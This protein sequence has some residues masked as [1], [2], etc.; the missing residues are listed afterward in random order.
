MYTLGKHHWRTLSEGIEKEWLMANGLGGFANGTVVGDTSRIHGGYLIAALNPPVDRK[1]I[2]SKTQERICRG[3]EEID[4][5]C[6]QY[7]GFEKNGQRYL[8]RFTL[9][10]VPVFFY[11]VDDLTIRKTVAMEYGKN[12]VAVCYEIHNG[13]EPASFHVTPL[14]AG[15]PMDCVSEKSELRFAVQL[16]ENL[17]QLV[18]QDAPDVCISFYTSAGSYY[19]RAQIPTSLATPNYLIEENQLYAIDR[20]NGFCGLDNH[21]TP[22]D[23][24]VSLKPWEE[25]RFFVLCTTEQD[26]DFSAV[27]GFAIADAYRQRRKNL[28][29]RALQQDELVRKLAW[30]A[31]PFIVQRNSTGLKTVLAGFPWFADWG[32]D[33]MIAVTGLTL[34]TGRS[35]DC[36]EILESFS[37]YVQN[38][39]IP[40][41]FPNSSSEQPM[42]NTI[43][44]SLWYFYAV[45]RYLTYTKTPEANEFIR[46]AIYPK[47]KEILYA[48]QH[49]TDFS[50]QMQ[51]DGLIS[52][53][54]DRDQITWM[55]VRVGDWV[56]TPRHGKPVEIN[57]LW[58]NALKVMEQL[59][60][61]YGED[62]SAYAH[63]AEQVKE[64][65]CRKFWNENKHC[66]YDVVDPCEDYIRPNQI[67]AVSLPYT[68]LSPEQEK[69]IV[70]TVYRHLYTGYGLRSLAA[71][72]DGY[73]PM[74]IG[75]LIERDG[76]YHMGTSWGFLMGG[77]ISAYC[78]V[79]GHS[80]QAV[81]RAKEMCELFLDHMEDGCLN[82]I[83][84]I[85]DGTFSC[86]GR[87]CYSQAWSVGEVLRAYTEDVAPYLK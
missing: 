71:C 31:D 77:F 9:D 53:G 32:R 48:Y 74:Y 45:E 38:G 82:G 1:V 72:E 19:D 17:L 75:K 34:C 25:K 39:L 6:Q 81:Q 11:R 3:K 76:A 78:K 18:R 35:D 47:L 66:L 52:G 29:N 2:L 21:Y 12:T 50:I 43:D 44:A 64:S 69:Q 16:N 73:R 83:A 70:E 13:A 60:T 59:A 15:R 80:E 85:F 87:G 7:N 20:R 33:T 65:F 14:F 86:T 24:I 27:D 46:T 49:G 55:D 58:Y 56:V 30:A 4:L 26:V 79:N 36:K 10:A 67:W 63:L 61:A 54:S 5:T 23:V 84:E 37:R 40:N 51:E 22:Y 57:A 8:E 68:M 62:A 41:V 42:Y 28:M